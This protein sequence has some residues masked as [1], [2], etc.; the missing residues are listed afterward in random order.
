MFVPPGSNVRMT[1]GLHIGIHT[2]RRRRWLVSPSGRP[3]RFLNQNVEFRLRLSVE[4]KYSRAFASPAPSIIQRFAN[5]IPVLAD[6]RENDAISSH[7]DALQV[8][9]LTTGH[10]VKTAS[11]LR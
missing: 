10:D 3:L 9:Q 8:V 11:L 5:F 1:P 4:K 7:A 2:N 6:S